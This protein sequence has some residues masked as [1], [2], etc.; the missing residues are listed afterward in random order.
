M[1]CGLL[2]PW[3]SYFTYRLLLEACPS[4]PRWVSPS[5]S[6]QHLL[7]PGRY[8]VPPWSVQG[9]VT[10]I[11]TV[12]SFSTFLRLR[13]W[14]IF[15]HIPSIW[16]STCNATSKLP[17]FDRR[18]WVNDDTFYIF[19][20]KVSSRRM[21]YVTFIFFNAV[22]GIGTISLLLSLPLLFLSLLI[23][24]KPEVNWTQMERSIEQMHRGLWNQALWWF[25]LSYLHHSPCS[26]QV[27]DQN[28]QNS[29][30]DAFLTSAFFLIEA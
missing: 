30:K 3:V 2:K 16:F 17:M 1:S 15:L 18:K 29:E 20:N 9:S 4:A 5:L 28:K 7:C 21:I 23:Q 10:T 12:N 11:A 24:R 22:N 25:T 14:R 6:I 8:L 19:A 26:T 13:K 27:Y